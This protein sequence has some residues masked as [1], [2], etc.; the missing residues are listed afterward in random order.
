[1]RY[2]VRAGEKVKRGQLLFETVEGGFDG[3]EMTGTE[4]LAG[5]DGTVASLNV[6]QGGSVTKDSVAAVIYPRDA[7]WVA[8]EV[9]ET[10]LNDLQ[11][12]QKVKVELDWN[13][14][15][16]ISYE[17]QVEMI[18]HLGTVGEESTTFPVYISFQPD[19]NTRFGMTALVST[20]EEEG[21]T[22]SSGTGE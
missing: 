2:A 12:G 20:L 21:K 10:D 6:E 14:D 11:V 17:G 8:A 15:Q 1:M 7:V 22:A 5:V 19:E 3:L 9:A 16:G 4:I 18:S 13:Q